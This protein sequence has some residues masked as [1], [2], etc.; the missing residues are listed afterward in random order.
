[1][2][3]KTIEKYLRQLMKS[4]S[5]LPVEKAER[6]V[7]LI[8]QAYIENRQV[9]VLGN[10]GSA[11]TASHFCCD[12]GKGAAVD[13][14]PRLR[15]MSLNDNIAL[16]TAYANDVG[17][18][19]VFVEQMKNLLQEGDL[20]IC[21]TGSGNSPNVLSAIE[22][23]N[24]KGA[25]TIGFLGFDGGT[26]KY[27]VTEQI[28]LNNYNYGQVEDLHMLLAHSVSQCFREWVVNGRARWEIPAETVQAERGAADGEKASDVSFDTA[29]RDSIQRHEN[30]RRDKPGKFDVQRRRAKQIAS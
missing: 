3:K 13:G 18:E 29:W 21:I 19:S 22:Y 30:L 28:T 6:I 8:Y 14:K 20:V 2:G 23:A 26:A 17:Y 10:G 27:M 1:M 4:V 11:A 7:G 9:F 24:R 16:L 25:T 15:V 5:D 12:L